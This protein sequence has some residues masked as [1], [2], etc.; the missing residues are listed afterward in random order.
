MKTH[1]LFLTAAALALA[2]SP[3]LNAQTV[4]TASATAPTPGAFDISNFT[5]PVGVE[6]GA[7]DYSDNTPAPGQSFTTLSSPGSFN[8]NSVT[9]QGNDD[10]GTAGGA[11]PTTYQGA[12]YTLSLFSITAGVATPLRTQTYVFADRTVTGAYA[13]SYLT[14]TLTTPLVVAANTQYAY[15]ISANGGFYGF[16]GNGA[17]GGVV[18]GK[19]GNAVGITA[20]VVTNYAYTRNFDIGLTAVPEPGTWALLLAGAAGLMLAWKRPSAKSVA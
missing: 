7:Q 18:P 9:V 14:F 8:L 6:N 10:A 12:I 19:G 13:T 20:P 4:I 17:A 11:T 3:A 15:T 5:T 2:V 1:K 16:A